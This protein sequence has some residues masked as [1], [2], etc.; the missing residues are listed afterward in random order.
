MLYM[1]ILTLVLSVARL[2]CSANLG[3]VDPEPVFKADMK[4]VRFLLWTRSNPD[5]AS[6][7]E[8]LINDT[9]SLASSPFDPSRPTHLL[10][11]GWMA[12]GHTGWPVNAK[13]ELL[14]H[15]DCNV[16]AVDWGTISHH[17]NYPG[18]VHNLPLVGQHSAQF[19]DFLHVYG[20]LNVTA[21][22]VTGHSL[23][24]H[25]SGIIGF[26]VAH[27]P[28]G[29]ITG[30]D[31][32]APEFHS[33]EDETKLDR[34]DASFVEIIHSNA[35]SLLHFCVGLTGRLGHVDYYP[36]GGAHQPGCTAAGSWTE[37]LTAGCSHGR[38][39][40]YW[41][42]SI[43][44]NTPFKARPCPDW[45]MYKAGECDSCGE[46]CLN[47]GFHASMEPHGTYYLETS[48]ENPFALG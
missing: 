13:T 11:H 41:I 25:V 19:L 18:V 10:I 43:N 21:L 38:S 1:I 32:A 3:H 15:Y 26:H 8:L 27:G 47:M 37:L 4:D 31:P 33:A 36:N 9:G 42:E 28:V 29:R 20:Q 44:G 6:Y 14:T 17:V 23:G 34:S 40:E 46:G 48:K 22:H 16:I 39:Y 7:Y 5:D 24:A 35:G 45:D 12:R 2:T 30:L